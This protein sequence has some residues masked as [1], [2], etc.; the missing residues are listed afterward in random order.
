MEEKNEEKIW[1]ISDC[2]RNRNNLS[3][4]CIKYVIQVLILTI[5]LVFSLIQI[6][7]TDNNKEIYFSLISLFLCEKS[8]FK[9]LDLSIKENDDEFLI[10]S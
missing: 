9:T 8:S 1:L 10:P 2:C 4:A 7:I 6:S 5:V 3:K